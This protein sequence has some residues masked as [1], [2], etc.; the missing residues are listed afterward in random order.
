M[1][2]T[3]LAESSDVVFARRP[4]L[5]KK[6][7]SKLTGCAIDG[8]NFLLPETMFDATE[9]IFR[10]RS[11]EKKRMAGF[12]NKIDTSRP[13]VKV[14]I[15]RE[16]FESSKPAPV[17]AKTGFPHFL[18]KPKDQAVREHREQVGYCIRRGVEIP[19]NT[20][21]PMSYEAYQIWA[22]FGDWDY[23]EQYCH[24]TGRPSY[25]KTSMRHPEMQGW[26]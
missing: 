13:E 17:E 16:E 10:N 9:A 8:K 1:L 14:R 7:L 15:S 24:K 2:S 25:G 23:P 6:L 21:R 26:K 19:Y 3:D 20:D 12:P 5:E 4:V 22:Q 11:Y 18:A